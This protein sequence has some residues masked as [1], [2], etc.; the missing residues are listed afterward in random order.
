MASV[1]TFI[2]ISAAKQLGH[3]R[4]LGEG[5]AGVLEGGG[6]ERHQ[7]GAVDDG[8]HVGQ[9]PLHHLVLADGDAERLRS[10]A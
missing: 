2:A 7:A 3:G 9:H 6:L 4:L 10:R 5:P 1:V 8:R